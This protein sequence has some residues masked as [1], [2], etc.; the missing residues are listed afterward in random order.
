MVAAIEEG[1][2]I[3]FEPNEET[4]NCEIF[5]GHHSHRSEASDDDLAPRP[6]IDALDSGC[7]ISSGYHPLRPRSPYGIFASPF[8]PDCSSGEPS[9]TSEAGEVETWHEQPDKVD[10]ASKSQTQ[11][12]IKE[13]RGHYLARRSQVGVEIHTVIP[14]Q[15]DFY[16]QRD[17][18]TPS[19]YSNGTELDCSS[20]LFSK[21]CQAILSNA[22]QEFRLHSIDEPVAIEVAS[23]KERTETNIQEWLNETLTP[24][25]EKAASTDKAIDNDFEVWEDVE[26]ESSSKGKSDKAATLNA[27]NDVTNLR[28]SGYLRFNSFA[29]SSRVSETK[30]HLD[31]N[32]LESLRPARKLTRLNDPKPA[33]TALIP[34]TTRILER[35][36]ASAFYLARETLDVHVVGDSPASLEQTTA[37]SRDKYPVCVTRSDGA[38]TN[39][40]EREQNSLSPSD[41]VTSVLGPTVESKLCQDVIRAMHFGFALARLE[42][43]VS[44]QPP[45]PIQ[46]YVRQNEIYS[47]DAEVENDEIPLRQPVPL[48]WIDRKGL[49]IHFE[50]LVGNGFY[51]VKNSS[52]NFGTSPED[53]W[54][55]RPTNPTP[56]RAVRSG[57]E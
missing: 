9:V 8:R 15:F 23:G 21:T 16:K 45:S 33:L 32:R 43:R 52:V 25:T 4:G 19:I 18:E 28:R 7:R 47:D 34:V 46:R 10:T 22:C 50:T 1:R 57:N 27:L 54:T 53:T 29:E 55:Q 17:L 14:I 48:R 20:P 42:G 37:Q 31:S 39:L 56:D 11:G 40:G 13:A 2:R 30:P 12:K 26:Q 51:C 6:M 36:G 5:A 38:L 44:P 35:P 49:L 24:V 3:Q 41:G